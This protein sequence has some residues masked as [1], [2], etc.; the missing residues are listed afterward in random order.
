M[1]RRPD[2]VGTSSVEQTDSRGAN[3]TTDASRR[4][5]E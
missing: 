2:T 3:G 4:L 5:L 1:S